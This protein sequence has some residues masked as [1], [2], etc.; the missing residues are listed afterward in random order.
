MSL[1]ETQPEMAL[2]NTGSHGRAV[3][4]NPAQPRSATHSLRHEAVIAWP[5]AVYAKTP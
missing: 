2:S 4:H 3:H 5:G 1:Q